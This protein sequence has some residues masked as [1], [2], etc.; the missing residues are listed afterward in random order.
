MA[1]YTT[2]FVLT[3]DELR[4]CFPNVRTALSEPETRIGQNPFT[5]ESMEFTNWDPG[6]G[7][8]PTSLDETCGRMRIAPF[9]SPATDYAHGLEGGVAP[10]VAT[11]PHVAWKKIE[12]IE[13]ADAIVGDSSHSEYYLDCPDGEGFLQVLPADAMNALAAADEHDIRRIAGGWKAKPPLDWPLDERVSAWKS[14]VRSPR[15]LS[16]RMACSAVIWLRNM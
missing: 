7:V 9:K 6:S 1:V 5:G 10:L 11:F 12:F 3:R 2:V 13:L 16:S 15:W 8:P 4:A 14:L